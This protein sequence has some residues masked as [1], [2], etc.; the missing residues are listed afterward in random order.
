MNVF[1]LNNYSLYKCDRTFRTLYSALQPS[2]H[3]AFK[4]GSFL[5]ALCVCNEA[6]KQPT[7]PSSIS[8]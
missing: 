1:L 7:A 8:F 6:T 2:G 3:V 4:T 5:R